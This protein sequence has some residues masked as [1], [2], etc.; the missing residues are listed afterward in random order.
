MGMNIFLFLGQVQSQFVA[1]FCSNVSVIAVK[2][3]YV[4]AR[5]LDNQR[6]R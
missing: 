5:I 3:D 6:K 2:D 4:P 1:H